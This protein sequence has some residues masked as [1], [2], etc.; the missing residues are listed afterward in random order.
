MTFVDEYCNCL[1]GMKLYINGPES[2]P[3]QLVKINLFF[4]KREEEVV[5][6]DL[7]IEDEGET[8]AIVHEDLE[9]MSEVFDNIY[10]LVKDY[11]DNYLE[12]FLKGY[13]KKEKI[14]FTALN[15]GK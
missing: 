4:K 13:P 12:Y 8:C 3:Q 9:G 15:P 14:G 5:Q 11:F 1:V 2:F 6:W 7:K 10:D